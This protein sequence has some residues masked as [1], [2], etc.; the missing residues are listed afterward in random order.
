MLGSVGRVVAIQTLGRSFASQVP[1]WISGKAVESKA[2]TWY[3]VND[4]GTQEVLCHVPQA[5]NAEM[6]Q[7]VAS[8]K[9]A[10]ET[11]R[12]VPIQRRARYMF[13]LVEKLRENTD[14]I[15][16]SISSEHGK[17]FADAQGDVGRGLEVVEHACGIPTLQMGETAEQVADCMDMYSYRQPLGVCAGIAPFNFPA[18]IPL[19]MFPLA[20]ATGN[21]YVLKPSERVPGAAMIMAELL[22]EIELPPGVFNIIHG[23]REAVDFII[24]DEDIRAIS[25]V[26]STVVGDHIYD[27]ATRTGKR[28]Q[29]NMAAKNH[30]I[31][32]PDAEREKSISQL[33]GAFAGAAGQRCMA[34]SASVFVGDAKDWIPDIVASAAKFKVGYGADPTSDLAPLISPEAKERCERIISTAE[35]EGAKILLDG[36]GCK[37]P[38]YPNGNFVGPTVIAGVTPDMTCYKEEIFGPVLVCLEANTLN[39]A[40]S[41]ANRNPYGNGACIFTTNGNAARKFQHDIDSCNVGINVPIPVPMP[42]FSFTGSKRSFKGDLNFYGKR[43]VE[44]FTQCKTVSSSWGGN[45]DSAFFKAIKG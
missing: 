15:A 32:M 31:V 4:P 43:G 41:L 19:W 7:A 40:I 45:P 21:T 13:R 10:F 27:N 28:V 26:G 23:G 35:A 37:V 20:I 29:S 34:L 38:G 14:R 18:M 33:V 12:N 2:S 24:N 17:T 8:A 39:E 25:F 42:A 44:F 36:R 6:K 1:L 11:W 5:T 16:R 30:A 9:E 22:Q 3:P